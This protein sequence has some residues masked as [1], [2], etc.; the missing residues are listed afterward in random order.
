LLLFIL[1]ESMIIENHMVFDNLEIEFL[2]ELYVSSHW[3][4]HDLVAVVSLNSHSL[5][6]FNN[7]RMFR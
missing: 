4:N 7:S 2:I 5:Q 6:S 1:L 3:V